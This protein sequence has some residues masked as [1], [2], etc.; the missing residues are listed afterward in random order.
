MGCA[1]SDRECDDDEKPR[2]RV[3]LTKGFWMAQTEVTV[4]AYQKFGQTT[5]RGIPWA[6]WFN[7]GWQKGNHPIVNV[8]W[9]DAVAYCRWARGR[10]PTEAEWEYAARAAVADLGRLEDIAWFADNSENQT[11][12][13]AQK[14]PNNAFQLYDMLGNVSEW[15]ADWYQEDYYKRSPST[16]PSGPSGGAGRVLRGGSWGKRPV[17]LRVA[18]RG[19]VEPADGVYDIGFRCV[20]EVLP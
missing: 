14:R 17:D 2:H 16:D 12:T 8:S 11:H 1:A 3:T 9:D 10:L 13:V 20:R 5:G 7:Q 6:P 19:R 18:A 4:A 15:C